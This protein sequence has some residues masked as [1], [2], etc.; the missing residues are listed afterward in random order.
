MGL[1][2]LDKIFTPQSIAVVG[3]GEKEGSIGN[4]LIRNL[5]LGG[6][7][8]ALF[9]INPLYSEIHGI[10]AF[11]CVS[12]IPPRVDL[13]IIA[14]PISTVPQIV[15]ECVARGV[16]GTIIISAG[17]KEIG[18][19]GAEVEQRIREEAGKGSLRVLGP[20]CLGIICPASLLNASFAA[21]MPYPG[22]LAFVSQSGAIC[23]AIL[24]LAMKEGIGF[25]HFVSVGS[26]LDVDFGDLIDYLGSDTEVRSILLYIESLTNFRKFMSAARAV[27]RVKPIV[28]LKAGRSPAGARAAASHTG[29]MAGEDAVYDAAFRRAGIVRVDTIEELFDC[30]ELMAKQPRPA[31]ARLGII[32]NAGGPGVMAADAMARYGMEPAH[33]EPTT[34]ENLDRILPTYWSRSNPIDIL[35]DASPKRYTDVVKICLEAKE[36]D[37]VLVILAPQALTD[38][39]EVALNL[40]EAL[41]GKGFPVFTSWMGG[42]GVEA[43]RNIFSR[44]GIPSYETPER[45]VRA[46]LYMYEYSKN[47][48]LLQEI[49]P[50]FSKDLRFRRDQAQALLEKAM[51]GSFGILDEAD[52]KQ[53]LGFYGIPV[54]RMEKAHSCEE[55]MRIAE[56]LGYP[57]V[58]KVLSRDILHK[59]EA[60][61]VQLDLRNAQDIRGAY[62]KIMDGARRH[63]P[64]AEVQGVTL[65]PM[66]SRPDFELLLGAKKDPHFGPVLLFGMGGVFTEVVKDLAIGLPPLNRLLA[67]RLM[68]STRTYALLKGYRNRPG[69]DMDIL[70]EILIR[71]SQLTMDFPQI[72]EL[73]VNP[74]VVRDGACCAVD[75][76]IVLESSTV[77]SPLHL[78]ISPYPERYECHETTKTGL[79]IFIRPIKPEDAPIMVE[80]FN[81]LSP[82]S[83]YYRFFSNLKC[84][85]PG[86]LARFTQIDYDREVAL[87][88]LDWGSPA[89]RMLGVARVIGDPDGRKAEFAVLVGDP[90][91]GMGVGARLLEHCL[92]I[93]KERG[94]ETVYGIVLKGNTQMLAL[95]RRMGFTIT[96]LPDGGECELRIDLK[97]LDVRGFGANSNE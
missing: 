53:L 26:M 54:N 18:P 27:S 63:M 48:N 61:G 41:K 72:A 95:G 34:F 80:L 31:G 87:V 40:S 42:T 92:R 97:S 38:A 59:T 82:T 88:A 1:Y 32:T 14:T 11:P 67:R 64:G 83:I 33:L 13:A 94:M 5:I 70:E 29:A 84:L 45:A 43:A 44:A 75:A 57:L 52:S 65:Q 60:N 66:L 76:R 77:P 56:R 81:T 51:Q 69:A 89:E 46:F 24:D 3:A 68:E 9:P 17:G 47:L 78:V 85:P 25:S 15:A 90:W 73:D 79:R 35:G 58:M 16:G 19:Q 55:A 22:K 2:N 96:T 74:L 12:A 23:T 7:Q 4:A 93:A 20:N 91:H 37:G 6:Y 49:P 50:K 62:D 39:A 8:K 71:V 30:A 36:L 10:K 21:N 86:M 28:V